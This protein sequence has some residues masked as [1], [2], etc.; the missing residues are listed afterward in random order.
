MPAP[1]MRKHE[2]GLTRPV[3]PDAAVLPCATINGDVIAIHNS[4]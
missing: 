2:N 3:I 4:R 1:G